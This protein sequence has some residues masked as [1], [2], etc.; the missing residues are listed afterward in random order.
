MRG[1][2]DDENGGTGERR[3]A[4]HLQAVGRLAHAE[5]RGGVGD[6][7]AGGERGVV[8]EMPFEID[9]MKMEKNALP[10]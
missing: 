3:D 2:R 6:G 4:V 8:E 1:E 10:R 7:G 9:F 5:L